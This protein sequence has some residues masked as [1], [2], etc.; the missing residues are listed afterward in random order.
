[1]R[2]LLGHFLLSVALTLLSATAIGADEQPLHLGVTSSAP[3]ASPH[4]PVQPSDR[5]IDRVTFS[6][7]TEL[8]FF[9]DSQGGAAVSEEGDADLVPILSHPKLQDASIG[10]I[11]W[12]VTRPDRPVPELLR[13]H[14]KLTSEN[15]DFGAGQPGRRGWLLADLREQSALASFPCAFDVRQFVCETA[16]QGYPHGPGCF[17]D[18]YGW[19]AWHTGG[20][21]RRYRTAVCST[22]TY[23]AYIYYTYSGAIGC[24]VTRQAFL[25]RWGR[26]TNKYYWYWWSGPSGATPRDYSNRVEHVSGAPLD[27]GVRYQAHTSSSCEI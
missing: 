23:D 26:Y 14:H 8:K 20:P 21:V 19:L 12:A 7:G 18:R 15:P 9:A 25:M 1:M 10:E 5:L 27:W 6:T 2:S 4:Q 22:G 11:Y 13:E 17:E 3:A 24:V 16:G